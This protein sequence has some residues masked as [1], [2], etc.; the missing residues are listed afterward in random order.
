MKIDHWSVVNEREPTQQTTKG[1]RITANAYTE[2]KSHTYMWR[3]LFVLP[4]WAAL[5]CQACKEV[6]NA[7][8]VTRVLES[9][10]FMLDG[11]NIYSFLVIYIF[12]SVLGV[13]L[14]FA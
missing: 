13:L 8:T 3:C 5:C 12:W 11:L 2:G 1:L 4:L 7:V 10:K 9:R 6:S 14:V